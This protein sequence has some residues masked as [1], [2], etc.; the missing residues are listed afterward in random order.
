[1]RYRYSEW[2]GTQE[3]PPLSAED[4]LDL[5]TNDLLEE[6]DLQQALDRLM[7]VGGRS[8]QG[9]RFEGLRD[10]LE[11]LRARRQQQLSRYNMDSPVAD[12]GERL[13]DIVR[14][15][16]EGLER[17]LSDA[18][19]SDAPDEM[20]DLMQQVIDRKQQALDLLPADPGGTLKQ[21]MDYEFM[22][23]GAREAFDQLVQELRKQILGSQ[24]E[25]LQQQLQSLTPEDLAPVR[26]MVREL[27]QLLN[28][29]LQGQ[30]TTR[31]FQ[32][33]MERF[34]SMFP[35]GIEDIDD[36]IRHLQ[37]QAAQMHSLL[38]SMSEDQRRQLQ[39]IMD[40][41]LRDDRLSWDL[42]QMAG[43]I[44]AITGEPLGRRFPFDGSESL[45]LDEAMRLL[46][47]LGEYDEV[48]R[49]LR[50]AM[51]NLDLS[52]VDQDL[53]ERL[54]GPEFGAIL[55]E[56]RRLTQI[57][58]E[59]GLIQYARSGVELTPRAIRRIG[60]RA[61]REIFSEL[62]KDRTGE[63]MNRKQ[64]LSPE[65]QSDTKAWE[66]GDPFLLD[67]GKSVSNAVIRSGPGTPVPLE[68]KD[69]EIYRTESLTS[70]STV[71]A[72]DMSMSMIR[73][74]AFAEAKKVALALDTLMRT[75]FPRDYME[76]V[77]FS[78]FSMSLKAG[79]LLQSDW[80]INPR[81]TNIQEALH[82]ARD[83]LS[84]RKSTNRQIILITDGRPTMW[85]TPQGQVVRGWSPY[86]WPRYS[87]EAMEE[88][89]KEVRR[90]TRDGIRIN[91][92]MMAEDPALVTF[93]KRM[94]EINKGRAFLS[95]P[96]RLGRYIL[97]DYLRGKSRII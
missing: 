14:Q 79:K 37:Q 1:M 3:I 89:L 95:A 12:I 11:R 34:G 87:P 80:A 76:L 75:R 65:Q 46:G 56:L 93:G 49:Q 48:E 90:C 17:R 43:L 41:L 5:L 61:L 47:D 31:D 53:A 69:L 38:E 10:L 27:N 82:R 77:V 96:G 71:I 13:T 59:A 73:S 2:D 52:E 26:E 18:A 58:E 86:D 23:E 39:E 94:A 88:T 55:D 21:L 25:G 66:F 84:K 4:I 78:Y 85:T 64:G 30:D 74:G 28:K 40:S 62:R 42:M 36:L 60:E 35:D 63:H 45:G 70:A 54:L 8:P 92:F 44:E 51:R 20:K 72:L 32:E 19:A 67:I 16:R 24:F 81:G 91:L 6:G 97:F 57:L 7:R 22:D 33:F 15:E 29:R 9:D 83:L 68:V 50:D